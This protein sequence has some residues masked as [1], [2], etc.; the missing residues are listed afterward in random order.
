[1]TISVVGS[2]T[3]NCD[4]CEQS[5]I[6]YG[7]CVDSLENSQIDGGMFRCVF[8]FEYIHNTCLCASGYLLN[9]TECI[10][11]QSTL[12]NI[13]IQTQTNIDQIQK[14]QKHVLE[15]QNNVS[16]LELSLVSQINSAVS[17]IGIN[18]TLL[19]DNVVSNSS[20]AEAN[21]LSNVSAL[22]KMIFE[23]ISIL[24][25]TLT[26]NVSNLSSQ[27]SGLS[28][29][30]MQNS[31]NLENYI[32]SNYSK[33]E[34]S[35][36][37]NTSVLDQRIFNNVTALSSQLT[38][39]VSSLQSQISVLNSNLVANSSNLENYI[40]QNYSKAEANI[41]SSVSALD[42]RIY[43]NVTLLSSTITNGVSQ[44]SLQIS[45][46]N[47]NLIANSTN[48]EN[49][50]MS[51]YSKADQNLM[52]N[53]SV[54]D[55]RISN[56]ATFLANNI[57]TIS[58]NLEQNIISNFSK[59]DANLF[60]NTSVLDRRLFDNITS[61]NLSAQNQFTALTTNINSASL[62]LPAV[63][64][65]I[66]SNEAT[67]NELQVII[68]CI[69]SGKQMVNGVCV[70]ATCPIIGQEY[71]NGVCSCPTQ[72]SFIS[73]GACT[74][75]VNSLNVSNVCSCPSG[76]TFKQKTCICDNINAYISGSSCVCP[77]NSALINTG[78]SCNIIGQTVVNNIC[79]CPSGQSV[80]NGSC[81]F[82]YILYYSNSSKMCS[83]LVFS[84]V[85]DIQTTV[86]SVSSSA[87]FSN[88]FIFSTVLQDALVEI[89][90]NVYSQT[91]HP[92]FQSQNKFVNIKIQLGVQTISSGSL[93]SNNNAITIN[94]VNIISLSGRKITVNS[95][96]FNILQQSST[97]TNIVNLL[98][99]L[100]FQ[101][102]QG[103]I[104]LINT[105]TNVVNIQYYQ[106]L[107]EYLSQGCVA[108][109]SLNINIATITLTYINFL[110][111]AY[112]VGSY[113]SYLLSNVTSS[114]IQISNIVI[115]LGNSS[116]S[117][118][119]NDVFSDD[120]DN[121]MCFG[122]LVN[123]LINQSA[124]QINQLV[125]DSYQIFN[126]D[127]ITQYGIIIGFTSSNTNTIIENICFNLFIQQL[128]LQ[129]S[130]IYAF[131][132][133]GT[134]N[135]SVQVKSI[136]A[137]INVQVTYLVYF[138]LVLGF[139]EQSPQVLLDELIVISNIKTT[140]SDAI[141][142]IIGS[143]WALNCTIQNSL[144]INS[145]QQYGVQNGGII[146]IAMSS[147]LTVLNISYQNS[148]IS[149]S[150]NQVGGIIGICSNT[151]V[152]IVGVILNY[153]Q[154]DT[155]HQGVG[156]FFGDIYNSKILLNNS[157]LQNSKIVGKQII[158]GFFG[159]SSYSMLQINNSF[160]QSIHITST[161]AYGIILGLDSNNTFQIHYSFSLGEN[162]INAI[163]QYNCA[164]FTNVWSIMQCCMEGQQYSNGQCILQ[165]H[166]INQ[167]QII[168]EQSYFFYNFDI[169]IN[170]ISI[171]STNFSGDHVFSY[172]FYYETINSF[173]NILDNSYSIDFIPLF[174]NQIQF[175][176]I[177]IQLGQQ[178]V[179]HGSILLDNSI[180]NIKINNVNIISKTGSK[181]TVN[182]GFFNILQQSS[183]NTNIVNLLVNLSF[184]MSQGNITLINTIT[185]VVNI[186]YYQVLGEY[187]SQ[188]CVAMISLN[189]N[190]VV[191]SLKF[192]NFMP[193]QYNVGNVIM[194]HKIQSSQVIL[195]NL[196]IIPTI[197][198]MF[199]SL[200]G[201]V[202]T[203]TI[204]I[205][206]IIYDCTQPDYSQT[207][208]PS[209]LF[210]P[211][212]SSSNLTV[213]NVCLLK[214][215]NI[216]QTLA[217]IIGT[218]NEGFVSL[219]HV[220]IMLTYFD[221]S[222]EFFGIVSY[223]YTCNY[224]SLINIKAEVQSVNFQSSHDRS[225]NG[226]IAGY[227]AYPVS[228]CIIQNILVS[229]SK[230]SQY[231]YSGGILGSF[232]S[233]G[234]YEYVQLYIQNASVQNLS[235]A[236]SADGAGGF[237]GQVWMADLNIADSTINS[238]SI[239]SPSNFGLLVGFNQNNMVQVVNTQSIGNNYLNNIF[240]QNCVLYSTISC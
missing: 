68:N 139:V 143:T 225:F 8:P 97:N 150:G 12:A 144:I 162:Y 232:D 86:N 22:D 240:Q 74:C 91:I 151:S 31:T 80:V 107:G 19:E 189:V 219:Q 72:G 104:T 10:N 117:Q 99:N 192:F 157:S 33:A 21:L 102:S 18:L 211:A 195:N 238:I 9:I 2:E 69:I 73:S 213:Q 109:I 168:C 166:Q 50:I 42:N 137:T 4:I 160:V 114:S 116:N 185:N 87:N 212:S 93:V 167:D 101:M 231:S 62:I 182:S 200:V 135:G 145:S 140:H 149:A 198:T 60:A 181:I 14:I 26:N 88:G 103:N 34:G 57:A 67:L 136:S 32:L 49:Y 115:I 96:F 125:L 138:G 15:V 46:L 83:Q 112:N 153:I 6:A 58:Y 105:I 178:I 24:S 193:T 75:G 11:L 202:S 66:Q 1:M 217:G 39:D 123:Y 215:N 197:N 127:Y 221:Q 210:I 180:I 70:L 7:L 23:N 222:L 113:S 129:N 90:D 204:Q 216:N 187:L 174:K 177:K 163:N 92:L 71:V 134:S 120:T 78:C 94:Q 36:L 152:Y 203:S 51:N 81:K 56:N 170:T 186:Q 154:I 175:Y 40:L 84:T 43:N 126:T 161:Y 122:G 224:V 142:S 119:A 229:N 171:S 208:S 220:S 16:Q 199:G 63:N 218:V 29:N 201:P 59:V 183:T 176:N 156:G 141:S 179:Q 194:L 214:H 48:L 158:G 228:R 165:T 118:I 237:V 131:G 5:N 38:G 146:S 27:M 132:M 110:P 155:T 89:S 227:I 188:G 20:Y 54:L 82:D 230:I 45:S 164:S 184:Q 223:C 98:V 108:M 173:I 205:L 206:Q 147:N 3:L 172:D 37:L 85:F 52:T 130:M 13:N 169:Q 159:N 128:Q 17:E 234:E 121:Q 76:A 95:G 207:L 209:G 190:Y 191:I 79:Q 233:S 148:N 124:L 35:L 239:Q 65:S 236:C 28:S 235:I 133:I 196:S 55:Q 106:V 47:S 25:L 41:L 111:A 226:I 77:T 61:L 44:L 30:L 64:Q 53:T 100:S